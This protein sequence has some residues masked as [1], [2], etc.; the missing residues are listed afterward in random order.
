MEKWDFIHWHES[1]DG[2]NFIYGSQSCEADLLEVITENILARHPFSCFSFT[3]S[4]VPVA[5]WK[6]HL[7]DALTFMVRTPKIV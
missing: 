5:Y 1:T 4:G 7:V 3:L 2:L 6:G